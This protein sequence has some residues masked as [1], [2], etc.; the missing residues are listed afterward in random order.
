MRNST[1]K[2]F[3]KHC[4]ATGDTCRIFR[5]KKAT[6]FGDGEE[7]V[8]Y[9]GECDAQVSGNTRT[10]SVAGVIKKDE[11]VYVAACVECREGDKIDIFTRHNGSWRQIP[12]TKA[13]TTGDEGYEITTINV[14]IPTN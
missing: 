12:I 2:M 3:K 10:F 13:L 1:F 11:A 14:N 8:L 5:V 7:E 9:E 4:S 6:A